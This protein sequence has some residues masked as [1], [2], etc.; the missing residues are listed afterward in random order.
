M[1]P[2][3]TQRDFRPQDEGVSESKRDAE[4]KLS[5]T[6]PFATRQFDLTKVTG[7]SPQALETHRSLYEG[8][9]KETNSLLPLMYS[10]STEKEPTQAERLI[11]DGL[12]RRF[13]FERN[14]M[15]LHELFFDAL[16]GPGNPPSNNSTFRKMIDAS[17]G[18]YDAWK[19]DVFRLAQTR[20]IGW[21]LTVR[22]W[23]DSRLTNIWIDEHSHGLL[24]TW[25][26]VLA[27]DLWEHA[28]LLDFKPSQ[29]SQ[30][31]QTLFDNI[32]WEIIERRCL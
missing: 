6:K 29:R 24:S 25:T 26:P 23:Q 7:L 13:A 5:A 2:H 11:R 9:V 1:T 15:V 12:V 28:Y 30:Y 14:G 4:T 8:Y 21:V 27:F 31:I 3:N 22:S 10:A 17:Y 32:D 20:G 18:S 19:H 16:R